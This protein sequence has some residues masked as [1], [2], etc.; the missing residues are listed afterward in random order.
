MIR[1][2]LMAA[3]LNLLASVA[4]ANELRVRSGEHSGFTR[5]VVQIPVGTE[6]ALSQ[7]DKIAQ[8]SVELD[9]VTFGTR[10]VFN[11]LSAQRLVK[12]H[13]DGPGQPLNLSLGCDCVVTAFL[14][15]GTMVVLDIAPGTPPQSTAMP[16]TLELLL[17]Q[18]KVEP[19]QPLEH[20]PEHLA[21][22][23]LK[24][25][26]RALED[27]LIL[28][29]LAGA[30][31][32][33]ID[34]TLSDVGPRRSRS[35]DLRSTVLDGSNNLMVTSVLDDLHILQDLTEPEMKKRPKC[36]S[37]AELDFAS[38][39]GE[40]SFATQVGVFREDLFQ[41]FDK[42]DVERA[43]KLAKLY[44]Y[45]GF[46]AEA[47]RVLELLPTQTSEHAYV[48]AIA[49]IA[50]KG[51]QPR[52]NPF[53]GQ[54]RCDGEVALWAVLTEQNLHS[55]GNLDA[56][57][58]S[59]SGLP[60][61]LRH[62]FGPR[63]AEV[64]V[65]ANQ[66]EA[67][68]RILRVTDRT[69]STPQPGTGLVKAQIAEAEGDRPEAEA[70]L[71]QAVA[72]PAAP[73]DAPL[74][75]ARLIAKRVND[76]SSVTQKELDLAAAYSIELRRSEQGPMMARAHALALALT[77]DF[78]AALVAIQKQE[79]TRDSRRVRDQILQLLSE[80]A[81][82][83][84]FLRHALGQAGK[85]GEFDS[86]TLTSIATRLAEIGFPDEAAEFSSLLDAGHRHHIR[87]QIIARSA[88]RDDR[89]RQAL[90]ELSGDDTTNGIRLRALALE[91]A[92][93][94]DQA[95][96]LRT[97]L[98]DDD[99]AQRNLWRAGSI[100]GIDPDLDAQIADLA[101]LAKSISEPAERQPDRPLADA[102]LLLEDSEEARQ[103]IQQMLDVLSTE[104]H[105]ETAP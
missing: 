36:V 52:P 92:G 93:E 50:D 89:P 31:R 73:S 17:Q 61:H 38:W 40:A 14:H 27:I 34:L 86:D 23:L 2:V 90:L 32:D 44:A 97:R 63:L 103:N 101:Q 59:F 28:K 12:L 25:S 81:D 18:S 57:E 47:L 91:Q 72:A 11:K 71:K 67:S 10:S 105:S 84:M 100:D 13:Q 20:P 83:V 7:Y 68:R 21:L 79:E 74:A 87:S 54:Q 51:I 35:T 96:V 78:D 41:E 53:A 15:K 66:L 8:L 85:E 30:D 82:D 102:S 69:S 39:R 29:V 5:L 62:H 33:V 3:V 24:T 88:I 104:G 26:R 94:F 77:G 43:G 55:D 56:I 22:P 80:R 19:L 37:N 6:W 42:L 49:M 99:T 70:L 58:L 4:T 95:A 76:R 16:D 75:L 65:R 60:K 9:A 48:G 98:G 46:G 45:Y 64:L 1:W